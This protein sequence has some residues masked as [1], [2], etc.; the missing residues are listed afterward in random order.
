MIKK[1]DNDVNESIEQHNLRLAEEES[2]RRR[3]EQ[4]FKKIFT[5]AILGPLSI[6]AVIA[7]AGML[8]E[9]DPIIYIGTGIV[10]FGMFMWIK[11]L[12]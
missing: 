10:I 12:F 5:H 4:G 11:E 3:E 7:F 2:L 1:P 8:F 6:G 9:N